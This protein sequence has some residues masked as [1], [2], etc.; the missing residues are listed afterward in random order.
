M[1]KDLY[2]RYVGKEPPK[3]WGHEK[4]IEFTPIYGIDRHLSYNGEYR[5]S[6]DGFREA[7]KSALDDGDW[8][9]IPI[10]SAVLAH[11]VANYYGNGKDENPF[12]YVEIS[13]D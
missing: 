1:G 4:Y 12:D 13:Y 6:W 11:T 10:L 9:T 2:I 8:Q 5:Y 3:P 7:L